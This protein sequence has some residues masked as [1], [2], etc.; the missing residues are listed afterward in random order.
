MCRSCGSHDLIDGQGTT[1][2][3][4]QAY[5]TDTKASI[6]AIALPNN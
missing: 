1:A 3:E 4:Q 6:G 5:F 2:G